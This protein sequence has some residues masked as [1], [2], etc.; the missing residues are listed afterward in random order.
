MKIDL[1]LSVKLLF[2][3]SEKIL[4]LKEND[5]LQLWHQHYLVLEGTGTDITTQR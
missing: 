5:W 1:S 2:S 3:E 4:T